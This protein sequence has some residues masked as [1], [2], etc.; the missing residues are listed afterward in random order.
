MA[1]YKAIN[2]SFGSGLAV[3]TWLVSTATVRIPF[4]CPINPTISLKSPVL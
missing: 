2:D 3:D 1:V 4:Q